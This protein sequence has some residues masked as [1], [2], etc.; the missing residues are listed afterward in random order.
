MDYDVEFARS[1]LNQFKRDRWLYAIGHVGATAALITIAWTV[2]DHSGLLWF[3]IVH[4]LANWVLALCFFLPLRSENVNRIPLWTYVGAVVGNATLGSALLFDVTAARELTYTLVVGSVLFAGAAGSFVTLGVHATL[5]RVALTSLLFPYII[6][7]FYLGHVAVAVGTMFFYLNVVVA[8][9]WKLTSGQKELISLRLDAAHRAE[10]AQKDAETDHLTGLVNRR[11]VEQLEGMELTTG[12]AALYFDVNKFK[13]IN[14]TYGHA[15]GDEILQAVAQRLRGAV[16]ANDVV[17]RLGGDEF[18]VLIFGDDANHSNTVVERLNQTLQ[19]PVKVSG[20]HLLD[21]SAAIGQS[22]TSG[23]VL[24]LDD[25]LRD[26]DQAMYQ[27]K[28]AREQTTASRLV[29]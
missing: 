2:A 7:T 22:H 13:T 21:I 1:Q 26:S 18:L 16:A 29:A 14:D 5:L 20:D 8:G 27:A 19:Q 3:G 25:L 11:G 4:H 17:A 6:I 12:V 15:I 9:V 24:K 23:P 28:A 10:L